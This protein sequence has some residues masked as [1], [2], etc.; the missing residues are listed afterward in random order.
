MR[1]LANNPDRIRYPYP[2]LADETS[3][4]GADTAIEKRQS[5]VRFPCLL[6]RRILSF[7][8]RVRFKHTSHGIPCRTY[9][10]AD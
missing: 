2:V 9:R 4:V 10:I 6:P 1:P 3:A 7:D 5:L 8:L